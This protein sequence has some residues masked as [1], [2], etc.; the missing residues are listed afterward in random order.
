MKISCT[1]SRALW[2]CLFWWTLPPHGLA[3]ST[4]AYHFGSANPITEHWEQVQTWASYTSGITNDYGRNAFAII[5]SNSETLYQT[6]LSPSLSN[7]DWRLS[8][9]IR[10]LT[11]RSDIFHSYMN[12]GGAF[13][14]LAFGA[15]A[16]GSQT[17]SV[18][19]LYFTIPG[20]AQYADY[21]L[22]YSQ[23]SKTATLY[24]N[25]LVLATGLPGSSLSGNSLQWWGGFQGSGLYQA[26]W[27]CVSLETI[28]EPSSFAII[29][30]GG[31]LLIVQKRSRVNAV[32]SRRLSPEQKALRNSI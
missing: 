7:A 12:S 27:N 15:D 23:Q 32:R 28:P 9:S 19:R 16:N 30:V 18:G 31:C 11:P 17:I 10:V 6:K 14:D 13:Y 8:V 20:E 29:I 26:N 24:G 4:I 5:V 25:G 3:Q 21:Q 2:L 22:I 1:L